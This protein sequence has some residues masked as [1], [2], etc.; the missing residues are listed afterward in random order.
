MKLKIATLALAICAA[1]TAFAHD[2][3]NGMR[4]KHGMGMLDA[5]KDGAISQTEACG[6]PKAAEGML[7]KN[8]ATV[9]ANKDGVATQEEMRAA[10]FA[11]VAHKGFGKMDANAD[12]AISQAEACNGPRGAQGKLCVKFGEIDA[13]KDGTLS[14][15]EL[16][17]HMHAHK[18]KHHGG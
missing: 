10:R 12:G 1:S 5:N 7:C 13:N 4:G 18:G 11:M 9:D 6:G 16:G 3:G 17:A 14:K 8:F 15:D 2:A